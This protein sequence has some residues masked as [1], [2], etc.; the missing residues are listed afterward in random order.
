MLAPSRAARN[1]IASP[2]PREAPVMNKVLPESDMQPHLL[3]CKK[4]IAAGC[5]LARLGDHK[6]FIVAE[7]GRDP[8]SHI[9]LAAGL[10]PLLALNGHDDGGRIE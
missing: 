10:F 9:L 7:R 3:S 4:T 2:M 5:R 6:V 1:A 8:P